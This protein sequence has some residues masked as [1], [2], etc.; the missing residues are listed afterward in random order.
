M[1]LKM[2]KEERNI[3]S[4]YRQHQTLPKTINKAR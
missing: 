1:L 4:N 2:K 3:F